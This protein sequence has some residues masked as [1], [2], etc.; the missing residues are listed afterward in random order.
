MNISGL[1]SNKILFTALVAWTIAQGL[2]VPST[3]ISRRHWDFARLVSP[4]GMP[5]SH[6]ALVTALFVA[7]GR[8]K[9]F[10]SAEAAIATVLA[11]VVMYDSAGV[12]RAAGAQAIILNKIVDEVFKEGRIREERLRELIGHTPVEVFVGAILGVLVGVLMRL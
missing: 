1:L 9:G 12:R 2:K 3:L 7:V 11:L 5:S 10:S 4:G 8:V 6:S